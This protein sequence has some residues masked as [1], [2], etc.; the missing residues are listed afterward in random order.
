M[1]KFKKYLAKIQIC[2]LKL[3]NSLQ[4]SGAKKVPI[5]KSMAQNN[6]NLQICK[7]YSTSLVEHA[8][9]RNEKC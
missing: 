8:D 3:S 2:S 6:Y 5:L 9:S 4:Q 1:F 7:Q